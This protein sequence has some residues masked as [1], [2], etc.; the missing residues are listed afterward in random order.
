MAKWSNI[1]VGDVAKA[2]GVS[3]HSVRNWIEDGLVE[4]AV[5]LP[6]KRWSLPDDVLD[7][8]TSKSVLIVFNTEMF[9]WL[10]KDFAKYKRYKIV[11]YVNI[12][13]LKNIDEIKDIIKEKGADAIISKDTLNIELD[14]SISRFTL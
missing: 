13:E 10:A 1:T 14:N 4:G 12:N 2:M 7:Q 9:R 3:G 8:L 11:G 5:K 6:N